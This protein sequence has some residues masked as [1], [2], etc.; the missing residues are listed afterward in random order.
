MNR[1]LQKINNV[2]VKFE[3]FSSIA[4]AIAIAIAA[5][6]EALYLVMTNRAINKKIKIGFK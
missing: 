4:I 6:A 2:R 1:F 5:T 3:D